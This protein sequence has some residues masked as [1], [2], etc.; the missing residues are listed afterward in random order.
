MSQYAAAFTHK[1][2]YIIELKINITI[3]TP[4]RVS[5]EVILA[6]KESKLPIVQTDF[7]EKD[8]TNQIKS[9]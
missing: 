4:C 3:H 8:T 1:P 2:S 7:A 5:T 6:I 9:L